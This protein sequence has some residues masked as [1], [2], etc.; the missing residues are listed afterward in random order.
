MRKNKT[1]KKPSFIKRFCL[2]LAI[3]WVITGVFSWVAYY[4][5]DAGMQR[6]FKET[7]ANYVEQLKDRCEEY[8]LAYSDYELYKHTSDPIESEDY[9]KFQLAKAYEK[10]SM[11]M[12]LVA[13]HTGMYMELR[14]TAYD[15]GLKD[16]TDIPLK[17]VV[18][19]S[20]TNGIAAHYIWNAGMPLPD[21]RIICGIDV[22]PTTL[23]FDSN[24]EKM[25]FK[26]SDRISE[27][28]LNLE[29]KIMEFNI[30]NDD[31]GFPLW[32]TFRL[33]D[34]E[35][36]SGNVTR[37]YQ[38]SEC[39]VDNDNFKAIPQTIMTYGD[40][41]GEEKTW[42]N[43]GKYDTSRYFFSSDNFLSDSREVGTSTL[44]VNYQP[45]N[46][47][48]SD[49]LSVVYDGSTYKHINGKKDNATIVLSSSVTIEAELA[50]E[51]DYSRW[52]LWIAEPTYVS[53]FEAAPNIVVANI[54]LWMI[55]A[56]VIALIISYIG[57]VRA[58]S[59]YEIVEYRRKVTDNMAHDLKT[60]LAAISLYSEN[61]EEN[62]NNDK[63]SYYSSKIRENVVAM[64]NMIEGILDFS[65]T[66]SG[67]IKKTVS[68]VSVK[69][70]V[71]SEYDAV[72]DVFAKKDLKVNIK[73][74]D[75]KIK[76]DEKLL[77]QAM[78][79]LLSNAI[80]FARPGTDVEITMD[81]A[82]L[83][84][85]NKTDEKIESIKN[86]TKPFVKG[87]PS[88]GSETGSGLGLSIVES[89]L[90]AAG[91]KLFVDKN[92]DVFIAKVRW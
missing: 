46:M 48:T 37:F 12:D 77:R 27:K 23:S 76:T 38:V 50:D 78:R 89:S 20:F 62:I 40:E 3:L 15:A 71:Q 31:I 7:N 17:T 18:S 58:K 6:D 54:A 85:S 35:S 24:G 86:I 45:E 56:L 16:S 47:L 39:Y 64:N 79:N 41:E 70:V 44:V 1:I 10:L 11:G 57:Y 69:D 2:C 32:N 81:N 53:F 59:V 30:I 72:A 91:H 14:V 28:N 43:E 22:D 61:L 88:R 67:K 82:G 83:T 4:K 74:D 75:V 92:G 26:S 9:Y 36:V 65:K 51:I 90:E 5:T 19:P 68:E 49:D 87:A 60:P 73:G 52:T 42:T 63:R 25:T 66:E 84:M 13:A 80:K 8:Y 21:E 34:P 29:D 55:I 33:Y